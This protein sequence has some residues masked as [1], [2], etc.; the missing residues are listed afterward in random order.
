MRLYFG[1]W[2]AEDG[3][4]PLSVNHLV[5]SEGDMTHSQRKTGSPDQLTINSTKINES[6]AAPLDIITF[7]TRLYEH[8]NES[9]AVHHSFYF[10]M[11]QAIK[12]NT[13]MK[14]VQSKG[15]YRR[16]WKTA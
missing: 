1:R 13:F 15:D 10:Q 2:D 16:D 12:K 14:Q 11:K 7:L 9:S 3:K 6:Q 5:E 4:Q 8:D